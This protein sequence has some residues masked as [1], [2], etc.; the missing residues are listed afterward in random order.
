M[1][2]LHNMGEVSIAP[3]CGLSFQ[4]CTKTVALRTFAKQFLSATKLWH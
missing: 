2:T 4:G 1:S 3:Y